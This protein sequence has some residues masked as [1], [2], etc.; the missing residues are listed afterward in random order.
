LTPKIL[1]RAIQAAVARAPELA[2]WI[3][4][5]LMQKMKWPPWH[6]ALWVAHNPS[7][8]ED[9]APDIPARRRLAYDELLANQ[10]AL[11]LVRAAQRRPLGRSIRGDG[12]LRGRVLEALPYHLTAAQSQAIAEIDADMA[13]PHRMLR[14]LQGDV[15]SGK[16]VVALLAMLNAVETGAQAALLAPTEI[17]ARQHLA[18]LEPLAAA[19]GLRV[20]LLTGRDKGKARAA[21][22]AGLA[23]GRLPLAVGTHALVQEDVAFRDLALAV[24]DEQHR[25]GVEQRLALAAKG[26]QVHLLAMTATPIPRT[27]M[28]TVYGDLDVSRLTEKPPGRKPVDTRTLP[29]ERLEEVIA[30]VSRAI[31]GGARVFWICPLVGESDLVDLA[32]AEQRFA[33]LKETFGERV[34]LVHGRLKAAERDAAMTAFAEGALDLLV[35]TTVIEVGVHVPA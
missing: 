4:S 16:T 17:L 33:E 21:L 23:E 9:L 30:A 18:T 25:F 12:R 26:R 19:A 8:P 14:L 11:G 2:E 34:G 20:A 31:A 29:L 24:V 13:E 5:S 22:L 15:G 35:A 10:L 3:D 27:L 6:T 28:M 7:S 32:A 1:G